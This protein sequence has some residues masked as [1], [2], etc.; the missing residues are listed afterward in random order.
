MLLISILMR[1]GNFTDNWLSQYFKR[2]A[3]G[4]KKVTQ[5]KETVNEIQ[6]FQALRAGFTFI[7]YPAFFKRQVPPYFLLS[8]RTMSFR[9]E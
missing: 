7:D 2:W 6:S 3:S 9:P 4:E 5:S 1:M 8:N